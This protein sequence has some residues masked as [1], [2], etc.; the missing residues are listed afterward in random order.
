MNGGIDHRLRN[1]FDKEKID[2][3][4]LLSEWDE[5]ATEISTKKIRGQHTGEELKM[6]TIS[7]SNIEPQKRL[8]FLQQI[9]W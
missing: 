1:F 4:V 5:L 7:L 9:N 8:D 2:C 6:F 3:S